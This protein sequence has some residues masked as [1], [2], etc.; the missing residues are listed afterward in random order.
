VRL[1]ATAEQVAQDGAQV[2]VRAYVVT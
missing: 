1:L 2:D